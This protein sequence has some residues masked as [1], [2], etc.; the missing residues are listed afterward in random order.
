MATAT[1][2]GSA[3]KSPASPP[4]PRYGQKGYDGPQ[5]WESGG[6]KVTPAHSHP[7]L[8]SGS[9]G[10]EVLGLAQLLLELGYETDI[11]AGRNAFC[12][13]SSSEL[14]AVER[15]RAEY[16][17]REDPSGFGSGEEAERVARSHV[18]VWTWEGLLRATGRV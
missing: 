9:A 16:G 1:K 12:V 10:A 3:K 17:V 13:L 4:K 5:P 2:K 7:I 18:A 14:A 6:P 8:C 11:T 15:F